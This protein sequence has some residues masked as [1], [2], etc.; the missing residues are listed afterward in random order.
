LQAGAQAIK[1]EGGDQDTCNTIAYLVNSG[2]PILGHIG[3]TPQSV[4]Q[5]GG[6]RV[7][8]KNE[9]QA[10]ELLIQAQN[11]ETAGCCA[12]VLECIPQQLAKTI[13]DSLTIPT[14]GIGAGASTD[15]QVLVWHDALGLQN[16]FLPKF[17]K[18]YAHCKET[19][20]QA[21]EDYAQ[22]VRA[23]IFPANEHA[24]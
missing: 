13:T 24:Y 6:Y 10:A 5:L 4:H 14:I 8:G 18:Q 7:Q 21:I 9:S 16:E 11:L 2:I 15:G 17:L 23:T 12:I 22:Q 3:L 1:I 19:I 20:Q